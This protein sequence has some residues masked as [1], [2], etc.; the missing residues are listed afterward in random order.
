MFR[1]AIAIYNHGVGS[2][3]R[4]PPWGKYT[5]S[6]LSGLVSEIILRDFSKQFRMNWV[7]NA[8]TGEYHAL[9]ATPTGI[10]SDPYLASYG[11]EQSIQLSDKIMTLDPPVDVVYSSPFYRCL[12]TIKP[13]MEKLAT[14]GRTDGKVRVDN[15]IRYET[16]HRHKPSPPKNSN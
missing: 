1:S 14:A 13:T 16:Q 5:T 11:V 12:Q 3:L 9:H 4:G 7:V 15:G 10:A 8:S 6:P 2:D